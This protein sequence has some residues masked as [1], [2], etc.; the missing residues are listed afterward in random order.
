MCPLASFRPYSR[1]RL[2]RLPPPS[3]SSAATLRSG[4]V[5]TAD[6]FGKASTLFGMRDQF[7]VTLQP[8]IAGAAAPSASFAQPAARSR[9]FALRLD[10]AR[11]LRVSVLALSGGGAAMLV[12]LL[13][14]PVSSGVPQVATAT[15]DEQFRKLGIAPRSAGAETG[16]QMAP[17][18]AVHAPCSTTP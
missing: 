11:G 9:S 4:R 13:I 6:S 2:R 12:P 10:L 16:A 14:A 5:T 15:D 18:S 8:A 17:S 7:P 3:P 1:L